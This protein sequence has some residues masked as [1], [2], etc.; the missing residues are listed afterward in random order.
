M[1]AMPT[2]TAALAKQIFGELQE[3]FLSIDRS[4]IRLVELGQSPR[5]NLTFGGGSI[6][7]GGTVGVTPA[8]CSMQ[9]PAGYSPGTILPA[10]PHR[11]GLTIENLSAAGGPS[12]TLGLGVQSPQSLIGIT[13]LA[14]GGS[15]DGRISGMMFTG[16]VVVIASGAGCIF[17]G[18]EVLGRNEA[19]R[20]ALNL[21]I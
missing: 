15:F 12:L 17:G 6:P 11:R 1:S 9:P 18:V 5:E 7:F 21:P 14:G 20:P 3:R 16:F 2:P 10:N 13:L 4:L 8:S 19:K